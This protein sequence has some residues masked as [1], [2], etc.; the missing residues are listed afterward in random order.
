M[1]NKK[2]KTAVLGL[3]A[4]G[5]RLLESAIATGLFEITAVADRQ[6]EYAERV[7]KAN[8][9]AAFDD[10][11]QM[12]VQN[13]PEV[14]LIGSPLHLCKDILRSAIKEGIHIVKPSPAG[15]DF[16]SAAD[17]IR[18]SRKNSVRF[19][20]INTW[21][22]T[23][24]FTRLKEHLEDIPKDQ[25]HLISAVCNV[26]RAKYDMDNRWLSDPSLA[27]GGVLL[28]DSY[29]M[30]DAIVTHF[31]IPEKVYSLSTNH[32]PDRQQRLSIT[33]DTSVVTMKFTDTLLGNLVASRTFGPPVEVL[34]V[35]TAENVVS[36]KTDSFSISDNNGNLIEESSYEVSKKQCLENTLK[37][38]AN[39]I[40][41]PKQHPLTD[42]EQ[43]DINIM[44]V[45]ESAY[46]SVR[47]A[48][49][50][51]PARILNMV[52]KI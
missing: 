34:R 16:E 47:T 31:G 24:G 40:L 1:S 14:L 27:G 17:F 12:V 23:P 33:E 39:S 5:S 46:L 30:I 28:R 26:P 50:E 3:S 51:E 38:F 7:A 42:A 15:L 8:E 2:L 36:V 32:A 52:K 41:S 13:K 48:S 19:F 43:A 22:S 4:T 37:D 11:R 29:E 35:H 21:R 20:V 45:V 9:C 6:L 25:F 49:P 44:A 10:F 18:L